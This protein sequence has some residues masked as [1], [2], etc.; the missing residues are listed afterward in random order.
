[1]AKD[2]PQSELFC[3]D[4]QENNTMRKRF[5]ISCPLV[6]AFLLHLGCSS[7]ES[8]RFAEETKQLDA[9]SLSLDSALTLLMQLDTSGTFGKLQ[10]IKKDLAYIQ[11]NFQDTMARKHAT[12]LTQYK[13]LKKGF[14][15][16]RHKYVIFQQQLRFSIKQV[17]SLRDDL[18]KGVVA[19]HEKESLQGKKENAM[20][21]DRRARLFYAVEMEKGTR[22]CSQ[23]KEWVQIMKNAHS[24]FDRL[25]PKVKAIMEEMKT[26]P[27]ARALS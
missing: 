13:G 6:L 11:A 7:S 18:K 25:H 1:M 20:A 21:P 5:F 19:M 3:L 10:K 22:L 12:L 17:K 14:A 26:K 27:G 15:K 2:V 9:L 16:A 8:H 23:T 4:P 24:Y